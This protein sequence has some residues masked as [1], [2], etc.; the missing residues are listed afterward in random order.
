MKRH[1]RHHCLIG[2]VVVAQ[3]ENGWNKQGRRTRIRSS[4]DFFSAENSRKRSIVTVATTTPRQLFDLQSLAPIR[5]SG[6]FA[7]KSAPDKRRLFVIDAFYE[8]F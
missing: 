8:Q 6:E 4:A 7:M 2:N 1:R 3:G 5:G